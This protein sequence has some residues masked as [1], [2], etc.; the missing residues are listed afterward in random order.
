MSEPR[1]RQH[2]R[3]RPVVLIFPWRSNF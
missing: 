2:R 3:H 1:F